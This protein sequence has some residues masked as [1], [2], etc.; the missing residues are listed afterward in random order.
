MKLAEENTSWK[1]NFNAKTV[2]LERRFQFDT[3]GE[4]EIFAE[5]VGTAISFPNLAVFCD[6]IF[7]HPEASVTI[8]CHDDSVSLATASQL[9]ESFEDL[10]RRLIKTA[11]AA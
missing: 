11:D 5:R 9:F 3:P 7:G 10:H 4:S 6:P 2:R 8:E 1:Y